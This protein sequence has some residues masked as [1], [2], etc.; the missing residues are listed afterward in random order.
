[1]THI[2]RCL[3]ISLIYHTTKWACV[4]LFKGRQKNKFAY[5]SLPRASEV[6]F[7]YKFHKVKKNPK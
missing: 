3:Q 6:F 2:F 1:M 5:K 7:F 4:H